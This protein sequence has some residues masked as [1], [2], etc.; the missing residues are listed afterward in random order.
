MK[1]LFED[2]GL[3]LLSVTLFLGGGFVL[4]LQIPFWSLVLGIAS[5]QI[6]IVLII[7]TFDSLIRRKTAPLTD[8][9]KA[10]PCLTCRYPTYVPKYVRTVICEHCQVKIANVFKASA[11]A[12]FAVISVSTAVFLVG[13]NQELREKAATK[14]KVLVCEQGTWEPEVCSCGAEV[15]PQCPDGYISRTCRDEKVYCCSKVKEE[16][17]EVWSCLRSSP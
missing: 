11:L 12:V 13:Q 4:S 9:Y 6:G 14:P 10:I 17:G 5:V 8:D 15:S 2:F 16:S 3:L 1:T 7:L